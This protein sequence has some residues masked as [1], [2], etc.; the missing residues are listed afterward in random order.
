MSRTISSIC[1]AIDDLISVQIEPQPEPAD[2]R[3][4]LLAQAARELQG[5]MTEPAAEALLRGA[6]DTG[7][8]VVSSGWVV[9][10]WFPRGELCGIVGAVGLS[11]FFVAALGARVVFPTEAEVVPVARALFRAA[12]VR[13]CEWA[14]FEASDLPQVCLVEFPKTDEEAARQCDELI[15]GVSPGAAVTVEKCGPAPGGVFHTGGGMDMSETTARVN[16]LVDRLRAEGR[17][18]VGVGD[19]GN[20]IGF[21]RIRD[22]TAEIL[23]GGACRCGCGAG[24]VAETE[25]DALVVGAASN[26]AAMGL[27]AALGVMSGR[28][29]FVRDGVLDARLIDEASRQGAVDSFT[30]SPTLTD[31]HGVPASLSAAFTDLLRFAANSA[32]IEYPL[33]AARSR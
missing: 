12:G 15:A 17:P 32:D 2:R 29:Q 1:E 25:T 30:V 7:C 10:R 22:Q 33:F 28:G 24:I 6:R 13:T 23:G 4:R 19:L 8:V 26:R 16:L 27:E 3:L 21:G 20:E 18:T 31:G 14:E 11:R 9:D 5:G